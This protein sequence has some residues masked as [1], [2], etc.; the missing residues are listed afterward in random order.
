[1]PIRLGLAVAAR[2][3]RQ[4]VETRL[5]LAHPLPQRLDISDDLVQ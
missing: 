5:Y 3:R 1:M 4:V 2:H